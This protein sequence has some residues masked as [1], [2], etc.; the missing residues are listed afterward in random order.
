M[1]VSFFAGSWL[2]GLAQWTEI[3]L[4][5]LGVALILVELF[6]VPGIF[7][8]AFGGLV[9]IVGA[10]FLSLQPFGQP[11]DVMEQDLLIGNLSDLILVLVLVIAISF[12][13]SRFLP[14][15]PYF[16]RLMLKTDDDVEST[17]KAATSENTLRALLGARGHALTDL[18]PAGRAELAGDPVDVVSDG[19]FLDRGTE[20]VVL[21]VEGNR[22]VVGPASEAVASGT[23]GTVDIIWLVFMVFVG[24][25]VV[26]AEVF[27]PS[28]GVLS[29][30]AGVIFVVTTFLSFQHG[31]TQGAIFLFGIAV[32]LPAVIAF[33]LRVLPNTPIGKKIILA[34]PTFD[35][36][37]ARVREPGID[38]LVGS[39]GIATTPLRPSGTVQIGSRRLDAMT[40]GERIDA[41][42]EVVVV[43][44]ELSQ[45]VVAARKDET[46]DTY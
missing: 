6:V 35:P 17:R 3:L 46:T 45:L 29:I 23:E 11:N 38:S 30:I 16:S 10:M 36:D 12:A 37:D 34:G 25:L 44:V 4:F 15:I 22:V 33:A 32:S 14:Q 8:A 1:F 7:V 24:L 9:C 2:V 5:V 39:D 40:R 18:R 43:G 42:T 26:V 31:L 28:A 20:L 21:E 13:L 41:G 19:R 27:F